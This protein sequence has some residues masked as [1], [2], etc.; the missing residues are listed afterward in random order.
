MEESVTIQDNSS[1]KAYLVLD[2]GTILNENITCLEYIVDQKEQ[3]MKNGTSEYFL[4]PLRCFNERYELNVL[5]ASSTSP[6]TIN[7]SQV[8]LPGWLD[9]INDNISLPFSMLVQVFL[10][11]Y[12]A[13]ISISVSIR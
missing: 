4:A 8:W 5:L 13:S 1:T 11:I 7:G 6:A 3:D 2:D 10:N 12:T 9:A